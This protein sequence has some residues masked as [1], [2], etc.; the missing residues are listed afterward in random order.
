M[1]QMQ[2]IQEER[3]DKAVTP[4]LLHITHYMQKNLCIA[5]TELVFSN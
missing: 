1:A 2:S 4:A 3:T 5:N